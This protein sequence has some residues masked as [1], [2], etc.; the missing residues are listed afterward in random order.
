MPLSVE[1]PAPV[2][3]QIRRSPVS[4]PG[5]G[6]GT[7]PV[8]RS[9]VGPAYPYGRCGRPADCRAGLVAGYLDLDDGNQAM[10]DLATGGDA[11]GDR[12]V[13]VYDACVIGGGIVGLATAMALVRA[14]PGC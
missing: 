9:T 13:T 6:S 2:S 1:T 4:Q 5:S 7:A 11:A 8:T 12:A 3:T 14:R 10:D